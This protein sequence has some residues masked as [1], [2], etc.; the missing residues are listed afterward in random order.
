MAGTIFW[1][2]DTQYD[3]IMPDGKLYIQGAEEILP[4]LSSLISFARRNDIQVL[5]SVDYHTLDDPE[6]SSD[7]DFQT[8][9]PPHCLRDTPGQLKV[10][11]TAPGNPYWV[12]TGPCDPDS[13]L[14][15]VGEH[16]G[17]IFFRKQEVDVFANPNVDPV[18]KHL[19]PD[20]IV[21]YGV[22]LDVCNACAI[23]GLLE[24]HSAPIYLVL[25]ATRAIIPERGESLVSEWRERGVE[26]VD[27][28]L[29]I[30]TT[31]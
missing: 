28:A 31:R 18:L 6:I 21:M 7:P 27:T 9:F 26:V 13:L 4:N 15:A 25:D 17:E 11:S 16:K 19:S 5:G 2:V 3:F 23:N 20:K 22:A 14:T 24:R 30:E 29:V 8:T 1:D 10:D 12:D